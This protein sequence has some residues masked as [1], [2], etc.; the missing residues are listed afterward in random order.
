M[1]DT[2]SRVFRTERVLPA[3]FELLL[4]WGSRTVPPVV[5]PLPQVEETMVGI[6]PM[7]YQV[8][9]VDSMTLSAG[10]ETNSTFASNQSMSSSGSYSNSSF[11]GSPTWTHLISNL[12]TGADF[13]VRVSAEGDGVGYGA[14]AYADSNPVAPRGVPGQLES[15]GISRVD[16]GTLVVEVEQT[17]EANGAEI[18]GYKIEWDTSPLFTNVARGSLS[19]APDYDIQAVRLNAW[20]RGW[21]SD[22]SFSLSFFDFGGAYTVRL[23]GLDS[24]DLPTFV[25]VEEGTDMLNRITPNITAGFGAAPLYKSVPRGGFVAVGRQ[26]FRV[27]LGGDSVYDAD[28]LTLCSMDNAY[29]PANFVGAATKYDNTLTR[30]SA[31]VLDTAVGSAF[32]VAVGDTALRTY[33]GPDSNVT[34]NDL[35]STLARG[36]HVRLGHPKVGRVFTVCAD[37]G[38]EFNSTSLPLCAG[39]DPEQSVSVLEGDILSATYEIQAFGVWVN[40]SSVTSNETMVLGYRIIFG[41]EPSAQSDAG[42]GAGCISFSSTAEEVMT[43]FLCGGP[44]LLAIGEEF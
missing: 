42:G 15:V 12:D 31:Y 14:A 41:D 13:Y 4:L 26:T 23:G 2:D 38:L 33:N 8:F 30:V 35:T 34:I 5:M 22:S 9:E 27:C 3:P 25:S 17:A 32:R 40:T 43:G 18:D 19:L 6:E 44:R 39:D 21:T 1:F 16:D 20:Q 37:E 29:E 36:D 7:D 10:A 11:D 28:T 24:N